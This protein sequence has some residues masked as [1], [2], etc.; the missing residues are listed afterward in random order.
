VADELLARESLDADQVKRIAAGLPL[1]EPHPAGQPSGAPA[2]DEEAR[3][4]K[5]RGAIVAPLPDPL[6]QE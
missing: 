5:E 1:D 6:P 3:R 4:R 2:D